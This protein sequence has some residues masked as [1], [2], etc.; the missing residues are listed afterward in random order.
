MENDDVKL[1]TVQT[2]Q[3]HVSTE[4]DC[5][6]QRGNLDLAVGKEERDYNNKTIL[7]K[8]TS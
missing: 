7:L 1:G 8:F 3:S 2:E 4:T 6:A 5:D